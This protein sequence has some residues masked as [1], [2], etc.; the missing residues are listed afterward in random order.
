MKK[1][2]LISALLFS[3]NGWAECISG[4]CFSGYGTYV[5]L[6]GDRYIGEFKDGKLHGEGTFTSECKERS[7]FNAGINNTFCVGY[8]TGYWQNGNYIGK[9]KS[10]SQNNDKYLL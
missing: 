8:R 4:N 9:N 3:F 7:Q 6:N 1:L 5:W 10:I 2:I